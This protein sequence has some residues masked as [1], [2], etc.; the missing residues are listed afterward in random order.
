MNHG[1]VICLG[2][3]LTEH[4]MFTDRRKGREMEI[5]ILRSAAQV[6]VGTL[7]MAASAV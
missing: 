3:T 7:L 1:V 4:A 6:A 5:T 2:V